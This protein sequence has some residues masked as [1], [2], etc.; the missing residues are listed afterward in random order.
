MARATG[1]SNSFNTSHVLRAG[2]T[3][4]RERLNIKGLKNLNLDHTAH[5][6][7]EA[8][9]ISPSPFEDDDIP[10]LEDRTEF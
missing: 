7:I 3:S 6:R 4:G 9:L 8:A 1:I 5:R 10:E 2:S